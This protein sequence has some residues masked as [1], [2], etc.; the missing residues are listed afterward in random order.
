[1]NATVLF[2]KSNKHGGKNLQ[3]NKIDIA[4]RRHFEL[5][6]FYPYENPDSCNISDNPVPVKVFTARSVSDIRKRGVFKVRFV[7]NSHRC[8]IMFWK[9]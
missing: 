4:S 1:M 2:V 6:T 9:K 3:Q 7:I 8:E 5:H